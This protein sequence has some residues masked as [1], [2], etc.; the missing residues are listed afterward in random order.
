MDQVWGVTILVLGLI[1]WL[2]QTVSW[3]APGLAVKLGLTEAESDVETAFWAD[4]RGEAAWDFLTGWTLSLAGLLLFID[5][6]AWPY[7]GLVGGGMYLYYG[8]R[9]VFTRRAMQQ[10][11]LRV[12]SPESLR[13]AY[14]FLSL[15][16]LAGL[17][18]IIAAIIEL[19][20]Q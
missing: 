1:S 20:S 7:L 17:V 14:V 11:G 3:F 2:G 6:S 8:G 18:T 10:R 15:W 19:E 13:L 12:G 16:A 9:G 5:N 4:T